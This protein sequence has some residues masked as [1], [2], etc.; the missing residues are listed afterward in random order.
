VEVEEGIWEERQRSNAVGTD[1]RAFFTWVRSE[2]MQLMASFLDDFSRGLQGRGSQ[3]GISLSLRNRLLPRF[4]KKLGV[5][6]GDVPY[7]PEAP[8][9][10]IL[11]D[12]VKCNAC[13]ACVQICPTGAIERGG[14]EEAFR[15]TMD[16]S[17]CV[18]CALC[19]D[20]CIPNALTYRQGLSLQGVALRDQQILV[21]KAYRHCRGC[22]ARFLSDGEGD[23]RDM[24]PACHFLAETEGSAAVPDERTES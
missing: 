18:N 15:L 10:E 24:C 13:E 2:G 12:E 3:R 16:P 6:E 9:A 8:F 17:R 1:R 4:L 21:E 7:D 23:S 14:G 11:L 20:V 22:E 5:E 19:L